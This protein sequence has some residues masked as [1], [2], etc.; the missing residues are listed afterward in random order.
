MNIELAPIDFIRGICVSGVK[1]QHIAD[2]I[3]TIAKPLGL[4][5]PGSIGIHAMRF[6]E[7]P[8]RKII[9]DSPK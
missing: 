8:G 9:L 1:W 5:V 3:H 2:F 7:T 6:I 4:V